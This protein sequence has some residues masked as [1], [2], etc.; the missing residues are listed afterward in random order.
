METCRW[1]GGGGEQASAAVGGSR[2]LPMPSKAECRVP[3][4][5]SLLH[6]LPWLCVVAR[7]CTIHSCM[8]LVCTA[9]WPAPHTCS[10]HTLAS[11]TPRVL[12]SCR[13][14]LSVPA[15]LKPCRLTE[16]EIPVCT[17]TNP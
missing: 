8:C 12:V 1:V 16:R 13:S 3:K 6:L 7:F 4:R 5:P 15:Q 14:C 2:A 9:V 17:L 10:P 11:A